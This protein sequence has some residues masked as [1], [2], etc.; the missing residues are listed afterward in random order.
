MLEILLFLFQNYLEKSIDGE[1]ID[2]SNML[3]L[4]LE[5]AGFNVEEIQQAFTWLE[6]INTSELSAQVKLSKGIRCFNHEERSQLSIAAQGFLQFLEQSQVI[7]PLV[8]ELVIDR[9]MALGQAE[10]SME[11]M[12]WIVL[13]V[14]FNQPEQKAALAWVENHLIE[15]H[16]TTLH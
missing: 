14:L 9:A 16:N 11:Q 10:V 4:E 3:A 6:K 13:M 7:D 8:R 12:Q 1:E 2:D 15:S 5:G